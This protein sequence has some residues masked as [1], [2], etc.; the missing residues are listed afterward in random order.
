MLILVWGRH[1]RR[2][3]SEAA[4]RVHHRV[5]RRWYR[6]ITKEQCPGILAHT[7][8]DDHRSFRFEQTLNVLMDQTGFCLFS[9]QEIPNTV[10]RIQFKLG[11]Y[12]L[13]Q[14]LRFRI[15]CMHLRSCRLMCEF[16]VDVFVD[17]VLM[18][19]VNLA[20]SHSNRTEAQQRFVRG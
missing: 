14:R 2:C 19:G 7:C 18:P 17:V 20:M 6:Q 1:L 5:R 8:A 13:N 3:S 10:R 9:F 15:L 12:E 4:P 16:E 11:F